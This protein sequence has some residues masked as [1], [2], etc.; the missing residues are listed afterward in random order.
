LRGAKTALHFASQRFSIGSIL[1]HRSSRVAQQGSQ[2]HK[3][4]HDGDIDWHGPRAPQNAA[5][6]RYALFGDF[7]NLNSSEARCNRKSSG[8]RDSLASKKVN[9]LFNALAEDHLFTR[10]CIHR[11]I[12]YDRN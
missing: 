3:S 6:R 12:I 5:E 8:K 10:T 7:K 1:R 4:A 9:S 11:L 2:V